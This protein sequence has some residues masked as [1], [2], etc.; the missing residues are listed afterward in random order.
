MG[1]PIP[2]NGNIPLNCLTFNWQDRDIFPEWK[3]LILEVK[4]IFTGPWMGHYGSKL[5]N[6]QDNDTLLKKVVIT[7]A[8]L[9][10]MSLSQNLPLYYSD[11][12][13]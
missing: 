5:D 13:P 7:F 10:S 2:T 6:S 11:T 1:D 8:V 4:N 12:I 9:S 3:C